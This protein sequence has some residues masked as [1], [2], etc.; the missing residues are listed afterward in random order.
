MS[1]TVCIDLK[2]VIGI[3]IGKAGNIALSTGFR[4][5]LKTEDDVHELFR[6]LVQYNT[7][8][9]ALEE[10]SD[11]KTERKKLK[12]LFLANDLISRYS[13]YRS[14]GSIS[15][16][17]IDKF[18]S[19]IICNKC[20]FVDRDSRVEPWLFVCTCCGE[21]INADVNAALNIKHSAERQ[22]REG[23]LS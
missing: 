6:Q 21:R 14:F 15:L 7:E 18:K 13:K 10:H 5:T 17:Y 1:N 20:K 3:D 8:V 22:I 12:G 9:I 23:E 4:M 11:S 16:I 19:S 2:E